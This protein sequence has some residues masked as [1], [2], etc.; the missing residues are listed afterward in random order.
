M[1]EKNWLRSS[2]DDYCFCVVLCLFVRE[3]VSAVE[4]Y[5]LARKLRRPAQCSWTA[6]SRRHGTA[7]DHNCTSNRMTYVYAYKHY[8]WRLRSSVS[9]SGCRRM[10]NRTEIEENKH[11]LHTKYCVVYDFRQ[12]FVVVCCGFGLAR[13]CGYGYML[14]VAVAENNN[15]NNYVNAIM[16]PLHG[17]HHDAV[18]NRPIDWL[19]NEP[20]DGPTD[21]LMMIACLR[22]CCCC[23]LLM[24]MSLLLHLLMMFTLKCSVASTRARSRL[25]VRWLLLVCFLAATSSLDSI[26]STYYK[27]SNSMLH[28]IDIVCS[29]CRYMSAIEQQTEMIKK[30]K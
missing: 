27:M 30:K 10:Q 5:V 8:W 26:D 2:V 9:V 24:L 11:F 23:W 22:C 18:F 20:M 28:P 13:V 29:A 17:Q 14:K 6:K 1:K 19:T 3:P 7:V 12:F 16:Q 15:I 21:G 4:M 25:C